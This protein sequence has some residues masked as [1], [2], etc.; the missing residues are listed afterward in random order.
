MTNS[1]NAK[2]N[3]FIWEYINWNTCKLNKHV[4]PRHWFRKY[5]ISLCYY[6]H[7][8]LISIAGNGTLAGRQITN[9]INLYLPV[10]R[11]KVK[12]RWPVPVNKF[13]LCNLEEKLLISYR[14]SAI[15]W[16]VQHHTESC[17]LV[18]TQCV[19]SSFVN[20][21]PLYYRPM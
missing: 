7:Y 5:I 20:V 19:W 15:L 18:R 12:C 2:V 16:W 4:R 14:V 8:K 17:G 21:Q 6:V 10:L 13:E 11:Q 3:Y 9:I 1:S